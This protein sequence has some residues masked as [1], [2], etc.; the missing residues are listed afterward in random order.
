MCD[1]SKR[2][3]EEKEETKL[4]GGGQAHHGKRQT[5]QVE[6]LSYDCPHEWCPMASEASGCVTARP[7]P[8][9]III[10]LHDWT[11]FPSRHTKHL[12]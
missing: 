10:S 11:M 7:Q 4:R 9:L 1:G 2:D 6:P 5:R 8:P 12:E 3:K